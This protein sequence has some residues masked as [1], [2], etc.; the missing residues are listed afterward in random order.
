MYCIPP[1]IY[2]I[3]SDILNT[4]HTKR[5]QGGREGGREGERARER[6]RGRESEGAKLQPT[7]MGSMLSGELANLSSVD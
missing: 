5:E 7:I 1:P 3:P 2:F 4:A 6:E